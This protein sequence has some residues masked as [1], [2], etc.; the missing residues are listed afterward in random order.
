VAIDAYRGFVML[1]MLMEC[2]HLAGFAKQ[3]PESTFWKIVA[4]Q[5]THVEWV[6]CSLHDLI[7]P[8]FSF[9][10]GAALVYSTAARRA[11][12][13]KFAPALLRAVWRSL[14]LIAW[15]IVLRSTGDQHQ[16]T[17]FTFEDTLSQIGLGYVPLFLLAQLRMR[18]WW[19]AFAVITIGYWISF[20]VYPLPVG[21]EGLAA[22]W[23]KNSNLAWAFDTWFLNLFPRKEPFQFNAGGY[24]TLS[25]VPTLATMILGLI[26]GELLR[27]GPKASSTLL[28]LLLLGMFG[29]AAGR[30]LDQFGLCPLVKRIWTPSWVLFSGG[31]CFL[32]LMIFYATTDA[33]KLVGWS[34][35][36]RVIGANSLLIYSI[37]ELPVR[38]WLLNQHQRHLPPDSFNNFGEQAST[39][40]ANGL[41]LV[42]AWLFLWWLYRNRIF[43]RV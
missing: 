12:Q 8:S 35:P 37:A 43:L 27:R 5:T 19:V 39:L 31:W 32:L 4:A 23:N 30:A 14:F 7:Q 38:E 42:L 10:V 20:V 21:A 15:G 6:G 36:L 22:H 34:F 28:Y 11:K 29:L 17:Y 24:C 25:F 40:V 16:R 13:D 18:W 41:W 26:G 9:L 33:I 1:L 2:L 3:Y